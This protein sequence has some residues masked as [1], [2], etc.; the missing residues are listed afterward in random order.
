MLILCENFIS[1]LSYKIKN[2]ANSKLRE[3]MHLL[4]KTIISPRTLN[5]N[6]WDT[7]RIYMENCKLECTQKW[8]RLQY[9][10]FTIM[11]CNFIYHNSVNLQ[12]MPSVFFYLYT[13]YPWSKRQMWTLPSSLVYAFNQLT[14]ARDPSIVH[15]LFLKILSQ[16]R[17]ELFYD[18]TF[19][20]INVFLN[21]KKKSWKHQPVCCFT[22]S[23]VIFFSKK[24]KYIE[25]HTHTDIYYYCHKTKPRKQP[26]LS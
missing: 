1:V 10:V 13:A 8:K 11:V 26:Q 3:H 16:F 20:V 19:G 21:L 17:N 24:L 4:I 2:L 14:S 7:I 5:I 6:S 22:T 23:I 9:L 15:L 12:L 18:G 25:T